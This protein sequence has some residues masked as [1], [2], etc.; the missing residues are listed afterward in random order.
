MGALTLALLPAQSGWHLSIRIYKT[1]LL[2][3]NISQ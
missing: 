1:A 3:L 2:P